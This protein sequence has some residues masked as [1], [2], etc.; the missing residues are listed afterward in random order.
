MPKVKHSHSLTIVL[1]REALEMADGDLQTAY[2][3]TDLQPEVLLAWL[4]RE[5]RKTP[6]EALALVHLAAQAL[7]DFNETILTPLP[8]TASSSR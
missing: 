6:A 2:R 8:A 3:Q 1:G 5:I 7:D 4:E